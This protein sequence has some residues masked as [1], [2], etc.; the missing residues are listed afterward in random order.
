MSFTGPPLQFAFNPIGHN[1]SIRGQNSAVE[2]DGVVYWM[3]EKD[4][5]LYNGS[6]SIVPCDVW[7]HVFE[8]MDEIQKM[9]TV[10]AVNRRF[11]EIW[12]FYVSQDSQDG[13]VDQYVVYNT[14]EK[15]WTFGSMTRTFYVGDS[16]LRAVPYAAGADGFLY[17]HETGCDD[18]TS[19][20]ESRLESYDFEIGNGREKAHVTRM[21]PDF[22]ILTGS[23]NITLR[24]K[25]YPQS[26]ETNDSEKINI[27][28]STEYIN[29]HVSGRQV[30]MKFETDAL[31]DYW[32]VSTM[33]A[34]V[35]GH[36]RR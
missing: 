35:G 25:E 15:H 32:R 33:R 9:K 14:A 2:Y 22:K 17:D 6:V 21:Y 30:S 29:P 8:N 12:W 31:G 19:V 3:A 1:G 34:E 7:N 24:A 23:I 26:V 16:A 18:D 10:G 13:E 27:V 4:I 5:Y 20:L 11:G 28:S 36:G